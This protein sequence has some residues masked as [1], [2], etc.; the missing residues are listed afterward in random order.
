MVS[1]LPVCAALGDARGRTILYMS[2]AQ[3]I[4]FGDRSGRAAQDRRMP[5]D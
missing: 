2:G 4:T 1:T 3:L 5:G